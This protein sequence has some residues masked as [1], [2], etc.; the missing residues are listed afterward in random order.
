MVQFSPLD[1]LDPVADES[2]LTRIIQADNV[3]VQVDPGSRLDLHDLLAKRISEAVD[4]IA[5]M[6]VRVGRSAGFLTA[7]TVISDPDSL[8]LLAVGA[9]G[10]LARRRRPCTNRSFS[11]D[12]SRPA[13]SSR[14]L[15]SGTPRPQRQAFLTTSARTAPLPPRDAPGCRGLL[16]G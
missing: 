15:W 1:K 2:I 11:P 13:A 12:Y 3:A 6:A 14:A 9:T 10:L 8:G 16:G 7:G 5:Q 4:A